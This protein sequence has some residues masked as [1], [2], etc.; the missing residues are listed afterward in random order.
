MLKCPQYLDPALAITKVNSSA[1]QI[2]EIPYFRLNGWMQLCA[3]FALLCSCQSSEIGGPYFGNGLRNGW[4]DHSSVK[5]WS[6]LTTIPNLRQS[7]VHFNEITKEE[8]QILRNMANR[9]QAHQAQ[10]PAGHQL[11]EM[12]GACPGSPGEILL[13]YWQV[14]STDTMTL[15][16]QAVN[17]AKNHTA[18][19]RL[20]GLRSNSKY[21][22]KLTAREEKNGP[23]TD[24][25]MGHFRTPP[26]AIDTVPIKF[27][28]VTGHD[29]NRRDN[30]TQGHEI[31]QSMLNEDLDFYVHTGDIEYY[32]KP[33]PWA[34]TEPLMYF[35]WDRLF[36]LPYQRNFFRQTSTYFIKD[37]HD[38]LSN[39]CFP[40]MTYGEVTFARGLQIFDQV[41]FPS[42]DSL[43]KRIRW[44]RDLEIW[45]M[46]GRNYR[47][48]NTD[49]DGPGKSIWGA[50]QKE[51]LYATLPASKATFKIILTSTPILGPDRSR[52]N[53]NY[54]NAGFTFEG[55]QIRSFLDQF[56]NVFICTGDRHW[57]YVS[58]RPETNLWE[59]SC[60][61]GSDQHAGGW[62][63]ENRL[64][65]HQ[66][67]RVKGGYLTV[68][69]YRER[70][71]PRI[72]FAHHDV[73]GAVV[74]TKVFPE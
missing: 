44:G 35:K 17:P 37:D 45:I 23:T 36:A 69:V 24:T 13:S 55:D 41:Q 5:I 70:D 57:Q 21:G 26:R 61:P 73:M 74:N 63:P 46:E 59:F 66:F 56:E 12:D 49:P 20:S 29:Y 71:S 6:R 7:G 25:I 32:D 62:N 52:K 38:A 68:E 10:I 27:S 67:L 50:Q 4:V 39:D 53:D 34:L 16:W 33:N 42:N 19:W 65:D 9:D 54:A 3:G 2:S 64:A 31:Y 8:H 51:W 72:K 58:H 28:V 22:L 14:E 47:S 60:G 40:G 1:R 15:P 11:S 18:Q 43:Y 48:K 30:S